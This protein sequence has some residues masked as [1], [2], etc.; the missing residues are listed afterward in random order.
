MQ[1]RAD[2]LT[3]EGESVSRLAA[4]E[5][6]CRGLF[7]SEVATVH[8]DA[9]SAHHAR[10][11]ASLRNLEQPH[12]ARRTPPCL[13]HEANAGRCGG[14]ALM[15]L[16]E[17]AQRA[18]KRE[19][20]REQ[21]GLEV[22]EVEAVSEDLGYRYSSKRVALWVEGALRLGSFARGSHL[23]APMPGCLVD[24]P[25]IERAFAAVERAAQALRIQPYD[26]AN[27][28][29]D[30]R[31]VWAKTDGERVIIT[32]VTRTPDGATSKVLPGR[33]KGV[34]GVLVSVQD[35]RG[36]QLRGAPASLARGLPEVTL[37]LLDQGVE[38]GALGFLQPNPRTAEAAYSALL[39]SAPEASSRQLAFD[40]YAGAGVTTRVLQQRYAQVLAS[41]AHPESAARLG[42]MPAGV[43]AFLAAELARA[44]R[45]H[46][47]LVIAN[48]P[49][50][51]LGKQV[52]SQLRALGASELRIMSCGPDALARE[53]RG[54]C[55]DGRYVLRSLRAFDTLPQTPHVELVAQLA[56]G[57]VP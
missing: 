7:P 36:N 25:R 30:L 38:V 26:E 39:G 32:L 33:I 15:A 48:P 24:H 1:V 44:E 50:K 45:P 35:K 28:R 41:E 52:V 22:T 56:L 23:A 57:N 20:L 42:I 5:V 19:M 51:G 4:G 34:N 6:V 53:L 27:D 55:E 16:H 2:L 46:V 18:L 17:P 10:A 37:Q 47:D 43:E 13:N 40:L 3:L 54:L 11:F 21:F 14:C 8:I 31:A 49:R 9:V 29:G 12:P